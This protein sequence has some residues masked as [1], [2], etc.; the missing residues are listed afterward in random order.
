MDPVDGNAI[1]GGLRDYFGEEMTMARG[2]CTHCGAEA[3]IAELAVYTRAPGAVA[4]CRHCGSVVMVL[5]EIRG[6]T[7]VHHDGFRLAG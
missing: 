4:R 6:T 2:A 1:A 7:Q 5:V 3:Q